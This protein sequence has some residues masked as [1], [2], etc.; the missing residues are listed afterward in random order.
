LQ[1]NSSEITEIQL[2][3]KKKLLR[4]ISPLF[5]A[6]FPFVKQNPLCVYNNV[7]KKERNTEEVA[8]SPM[9]LILELDY[10]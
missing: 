10:V 6:L 9:T 5:K 8:V 2:L 4:K 3:Q 1:I 7:L